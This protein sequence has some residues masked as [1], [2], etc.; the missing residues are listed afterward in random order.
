MMMIHDDYVYI[1]AQRAS[2]GNTEL[3]FKDIKENEALPDAL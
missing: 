3:A 1:T 2:R